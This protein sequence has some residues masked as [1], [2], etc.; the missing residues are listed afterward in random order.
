V[1]D[2][3]EADDTPVLAQ[4]VE[5]PLTAPVE[6]AVE[7]G[8]EPIPQ[9][10]T[11][12]P[13]GAVVHNDEVLDQS[14]TPEQLVETE[15]KRAVEQAKRAAAQRA[16]L[17]QQRKDQII[18]DMRTSLQ[19]REEERARLIR[20][21]VE[22]Q[23]KIAAFMATQK[24]RDA[25]APGSTTNQLQKEN[26]AASMAETERQYADTLNVILDLKNKIRRQQNESDVVAGEL[27]YR[28]D[29]KQFKAEAISKSFS[30][31]KREIALT[32]ENSRTGKPIPSRMVDEFERW[33][34]RKN[35]EMEK[36]RLKN[37]ML[38][39]NL[40]KLEKRLKTKEQ[41]AE[42]LHL[43]DFE[44]LKIENQTLSEKIE[45][46]N[47]ELQK[48]RRK[49]TVTVQVLTHVKEK[50]QFVTKENE[51]VK[52]RLLQLD[53]ELTHKREKLRRAKKER[54]RWRAA[55]SNLKQNQGFASS[56]L[57]VAD[58][59]QRKLKLDFMKA[60]LAELKDQHR[61]LINE[62]KSFEIPD[63]MVPET[64]VPETNP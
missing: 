57:L 36:V 9:D 16:E 50:L 10:D 21:Q 4:V 46:R 35:E 53:Q 61:I 13:E 22:L 42:G 51:S 62:T 25:N 28:L 24:M 34:A 19:Q 43:I 39:M 15:K 33:E 64:M 32:S 2:V 49:N 44:Q 11:S 18:A 41:L 56:D 17:E 29:E 59:E 55:N 60:N 31:F 52:E 20:E 7:G 1:A 45:E 30:E 6:I 8:Q 37:I 54:D 27:Q 12:A 3:V 48:L 47:E 14:L 63:A 40:K 5:E 23:K 58:F 38:R 26:D